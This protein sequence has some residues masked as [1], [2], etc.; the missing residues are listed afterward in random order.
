M[1]CKVNLYVKKLT[2]KIKVIMSFGRY[3]SLKPTRIAALTR[4]TKENVFGKLKLDSTGQ[5]SFFMP[6]NVSAVE[7]PES[8]DQLIEI[9]EILI[10]YNHENQE[11]TQKLVKFIEEHPTIGQY[12]LEVSISIRPR[13]V[14]EYVY[15]FN[16]FSPLLKKHLQTTFVAPQD[17]ID[18]L[19]ETNE[20]PQYLAEKFQYRL[21]YPEVDYSKYEYPASMLPNKENPFKLSKEMLNALINDDVDYIVQQSALADFKPKK[22]YGL[23]FFRF[24]IIEAAALFGAVKIYKFCLTNGIGSDHIHPFVVAGG[25]LE[26]VRI[27]AAA[28]VTQS[29]FN[30]T[31]N[32]AI[33][34]RHDELYSWIRENYPERRGPFGFTQFVRS[35]ST[36][37]LKGL[38]AILKASANVSKKFKFADYIIMLTYDGL[39]GIA[40]ELCPFV[41]LTFELFMIANDDEMLNNLISNRNP[42]DIP[43]EFFRHTLQTKSKKHIEALVNHP[44][45][46]E[47][48]FHDEDI[49]LMKKNAPWVLEKLYDIFDKTES[50]EQMIKMYDHGFPVRESKV[51]ELIE[52]LA[53]QDRTLNKKSVDDLVK[54]F[55]P[56]L[57]KEFLIHL[58]EINGSLWSFIVDFMFGKTQRDALSFMMDPTKREKVKP[59]TTFINEYDINSADIKKLI[60]TYRPYYYGRMNADFLGLIIS[61]IDE[62]DEEDLLLLYLM[63]RDVTIESQLRK[64]L[65]IPQKV[66][67]FGTEQIRNILDA[68]QDLAANLLVC[69]PR[70]VKVIL[71][72]IDEKSLK[73][74]INAWKIKPAD[75]FQNYIVNNPGF[76]Q[77]V[78]IK[79]LSK[80]P[81]LLELI[82]SF[83]L[84][85]EEFNFLADN[86]DYEEIVCS[87]LYNLKNA[88]HFS[89]QDLF[90]NDI[91][92]KFDLSQKFCYANGKIDKPSVNMINS[93]LRFGYLP[94]E[95]VEFVLKNPIV[96]QNVQLEGLHGALKKVSDPMLVFNCMKGRFDQFKYHELINFYKLLS[97]KNKKIFL[98]NLNPPK[99]FLFHASVIGLKNII[100]GEF[101][102]EEHD[103]INFA[104]DFKDPHYKFIFDTYNMDFYC[105]KYLFFKFVE[106][107]NVEYMDKLVTKYNFDI[108]TLNYLSPLQYS[109][110][111][112]AQDAFDY[113]LSKNAD[114][115][116]RGL[117]TSLT[118][119]EIIKRTRYYK[120]KVKSLIPNMEEEAKMNDR[121]DYFAEYKYPRDL[122]QSILYIGPQIDQKGLPTNLS[123]PNLSFE[124]AFL[125]MMRS[126]DFPVLNKTLVACEPLM[127]LR[128]PQD[129]LMPIES[130]AG[131]LNAACDNVKTIYGIITGKPEFICKSDYLSY[132]LHFAVC[133]GS[134]AV[135]AKMFQ[136]GADLSKVEGN[137]NYYSPAIESILMNRMD[138]F[139]IL[140]NNGLNINTVYPHQNLTLL[141]LSII[142]S[143]E[144]FD[145]LYNKVTINY[146]LAITPV[147]CLPYIL[148]QSRIPD[149]VRKVLSVTNIE[150]E[151][152][153]N[154]FFVSIAPVLLSD[155]QIT[156]RNWIED[157][158]TFHKNTITDSKDQDLIT[159]EIPD[160]MNENE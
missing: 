117:T 88:K 31:S 158:K 87:T 84:T 7:V 67:L 107:N 122:F 154:T 139:I 133:F 82:L 73:I 151:K 59:T 42:L 157:F 137:I 14:K 41:G 127:Y 106:F 46:Y 74:L 134:P 4:N 11:N 13:L 109:I 113:L 57:T 45:F 120:D 99:L 48:Y 35:L 89:V 5:E 44:K 155:N 71:P 148:D 78:D 131:G 111:C 17:F 52:A 102:V 152:K 98:E 138:I 145:Y 140:V 76:K 104:K 64:K 22:I 15:L 37:S 66:S 81:K 25:N 68:N 142:H 156:R 72:T 124:M 160:F 97:A 61:L 136:L 8:F 146:N 94:P 128:L 115:S 121:I 32:I 20:Y 16:Q 19:I 86:P 114:V 30:Q 62:F 55:K 149:V 75:E 21:Q 12:E 130:L 26:I 6:D 65:N 47:F 18:F 126:F 43:T 34:Y 60:R 141:N 144:I 38:Y 3:D 1:S 135:I 70:F 159:P 23:R 10:N 29:K 50:I 24:T 123:A 58:T 77:F 51:L 90:F 118:F 150:Q 40:K 116:F 105:Q 2:N 54:Q 69:D 132:L 125:M 53:T 63:Y 147:M 108:E 85:E 93:E 36:L 9:E 153:V 92:E 33:A 100:E 119:A 27:T 96:Q 91:A 80:D 129:Q 39:I 28:E 112:E 79:E 95:L 143:Q 56:I 49:K 110:I 101:T 83:E 103:L